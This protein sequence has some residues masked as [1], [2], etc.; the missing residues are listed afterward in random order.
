MWR[1]ARCF[2]GGTTVSG[3]L[4]LLTR[5]QTFVDAKM[6]VPCYNE[7]MVDAA[8]WRTEETKIMPQMVWAFFC[9]KGP[10][11][12]LP[13]WAKLTV[14]FWAKYYDT[15][16]GS[17]QPIAPRV[18]L[19]LSGTDAPLEVKCVTTDACPLL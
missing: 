2:G 12:K 13:E 17:S 16:E 5:C 19:D 1:W 3:R 9:T 11:D 14:Q 6:S 10:D 4:V 8:N 15:Y 7:A 18:A